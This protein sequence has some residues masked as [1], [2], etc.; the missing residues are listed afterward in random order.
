[1]YATWDTNAPTGSIK[2]ASKMT[3][4][5]TTANGYKVTLNPNGGIC[6]K[7]GLTAVNT[8]EWNFSNWNTA[9]DGSGTSYSAESKYSKNSGATMYA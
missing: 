2:L 7:E 8:I 9:A 5:D 1:M 3:K 4:G 6:D